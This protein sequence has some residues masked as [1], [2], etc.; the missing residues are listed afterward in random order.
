MITKQLHHRLNRRIMHTLLLGLL[1]LAMVLTLTPRVRAAEINPSAS[2]YRYG[3]TSEFSASSSAAGSSSTTDSLANT[4]QNQKLY[5]ALALT[6]V[7]LGIGILL[8]RK[9]A[10][11]K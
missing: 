10:H 5:G 2:T 4:G 9:S 7:S 6:L 1:T 3:S 8:F 11:P